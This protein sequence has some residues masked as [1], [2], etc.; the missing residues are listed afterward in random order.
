MT[1]D[2][3]SLLSPTAAVE[4]CTPAR[5]HLGM[6]SFGVAGGRSFGGVGVMID[7][8]GVQLR[9]RRAKRYEATGPLA[10]RAVAFAK[11]C[12]EAWRLG[13]RV[14]CGIEVID[15]PGSH[16]GLG[17]G[18]QLGLAVAA[19][20]RQLYRPRA[21]AQGQQAERRFDIRDAVEL[22]RGVGRG[23]RSCVGIY[24]FSGGGLIV[25]G[26][27]LMPADRVAEDDATRSFSPLLAR[28]HLPEQWRCVVFSMRNAVGLHGDAEKQAFASLPPVTLEISAELSR[29]AL[30]DLWPAAVEGR[31]AEFSDAV[32]RYG[33]LAGQPFAEVSSRLPH[34]QATERLIDS[35]VAIGARGSAQSSWGPTVMACCESPAAADAVVGQFAKNDLSRSYNTTIARFDTQGAVLRDI[36]WNPAQDTAR[37]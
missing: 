19:G 31:F 20:M 12:V 30:M 26:G 4:I 34:A 22:A 28:V 32:L 6:L 10:D 29:I 24:G 18:T 33:R 36:V 37:P 16:A 35:L 3:P 9:I 14:A 21:E 1:Q 27:R 8:P 5:L 7:R 23:R 15:V 25:E 13:E 17:S 11:A 2:H